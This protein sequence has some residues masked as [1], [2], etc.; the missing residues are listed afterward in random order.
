MGAMNTG[1]NKQRCR[2]AVPLSTDWDPIAEARSRKPVERPMTGE[3]ER[4]AAILDGRADFEAR[5]L[6]TL[7]RGVVVLSVARPVEVTAENALDFLRAL[8]ERSEGDR[9]VVLDAIEIR[10]IE[11][12]GMDALLDLQD[13]LVR[14]GGGFALARPSSLV[15]EVLHL[16]GLDC[17]IKIY[18]TLPT[19]IDRLLLESEGETTWS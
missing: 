10:H 3:A 9:L 18:P 19:A 5:I 6:R 14:C 2:K 16:A 13:T 12:D 7:Q 1:T 8:R 4:A 15:A 11:N 17:Q